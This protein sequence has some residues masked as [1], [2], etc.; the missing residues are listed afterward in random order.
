M[1]PAG[2]VAYRGTGMA[3]SA[4]ECALWISQID[5]MIYGEY[6][7]KREIFTQYTNNQLENGLEAASIWPASSC[8]GMIDFSLQRISRSERHFKP[9]FPSQQVVYSSGCLLEQIEC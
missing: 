7:R 6:L 2:V 1:I 3:I 8:E 5:K 9:H 4:G